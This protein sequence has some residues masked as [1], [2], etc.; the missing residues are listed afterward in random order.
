MNLQGRQFSLLAALACGLAVP[1][2]AELST[3]SPFLP[4]SQGQVAAQAGGPLEFRG[5][6]VLGGDSFFNLLD[7]STR[8]SS[9]VRLNETGNAFVVKS[10]DHSGPNEIVSVEY[11]GRLVSLPLM[12]PKTGKG[13]RAAG[14]P[15]AAQAANAAAGAGQGP[16]SPVVLNPTPADEA[17]RA[18]AFRAEILRRRLLRQQ[19]AEGASAAP[20]PKAR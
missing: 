10:Y 12:Q 19:A 11:Q 20:Q 16:I 7:T 13:P 14:L 18:E 9:W 2:L 3:Q 6:M 17:R 5:I 8:K 4:P 1:C 15:L